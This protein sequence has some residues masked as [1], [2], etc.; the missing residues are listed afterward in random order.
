M[1]LVGRR[2][3]HLAC[4]KL[5]GG[6]LVWLCL[7]LGADLHTAQLMPLPLTVSC[8]GKILIGFTFLVPAHLSSPRQR[9]VKRTC[10]CVTIIIGSFAVTT[11]IQFFPTRRTCIQCLSARASVLNQMNQLRCYFGGIFMWAEG[12][13]YHI[14]VQIPKGGGI[15]VG[16]CLGTNPE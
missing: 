1:L 13:L 3:G 12:T 6:V 7:Q 9:A 10:V 5:S 8:F 15:F 2:E 4:K 14:R 11:Q 16:L